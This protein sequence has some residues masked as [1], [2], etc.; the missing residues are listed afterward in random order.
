VALMDA[1]NFC[2]QRNIHSSSMHAVA[3]AMGN[4]PITSIVSTAG[5]QWYFMANVPF[6]AGDDFHVA[7][8]TNAIV[9]Q[10][11]VSPHF[12]GYFN[13]LHCSLDFDLGMHPTS[14]ISSIEDFRRSHIAFAAP[15]ALCSSFEPAQIV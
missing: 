5:F 10:E 9:P 4:Q 3:L 6:L 12:G 14:I 8:M 7:Q 2:D 15:R 11:Y 13:S 1:L